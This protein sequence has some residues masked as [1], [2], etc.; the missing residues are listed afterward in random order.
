MSQIIV[1]CGTGTSSQFVVINNYNYVPNI[2]QSTAWP[3]QAVYIY[4][5]LLI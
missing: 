2:H 1:W 3:L 5:F 4:N